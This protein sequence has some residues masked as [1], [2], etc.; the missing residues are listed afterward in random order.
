VGKREG[1]IPQE[2]GPGPRGISQFFGTKSHSIFF[3]Y[4]TY[5]SRCCVGNYVFAMGLAPGCEQSCEILVWWRPNKHPDEGPSFPGHPRTLFSSLPHHN[6]SSEPL[7]PSEK[8]LHF[9]TIY[10][11]FRTSFQSQISPH[12][13]RE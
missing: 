12:L 6:L 1:C 11:T 13:A 5:L 2:E 9:F 7:C 3:Q 4:R 8:L 10:H